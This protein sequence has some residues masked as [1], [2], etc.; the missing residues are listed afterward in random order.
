MADNNAVGTAGEF[1]AAGSYEFIILE[2]NPQGIARVTLNRPDSLNSLSGPLTKEL[3]TA[4]GKLEKDAAV[5]AII[6]TGAGRGFS[7]GADLK[8]GPTEG[9]PADWIREYYNPLIMKMRHLEKPIIAAV[10][11]VAAGA[12]F[13][14]A[15]ACDF[16]IVSEKARFISAFIRIGLV[17]DSGLAYFLP[18]LVGA[19]R[20]LE[21]TATGDEVSAAKA[22]EYGMVNRVVAPEQLEVETLAFANKLAQGPTYGI[23]LTKKLIN[24]G[25]ERSLSEVLEME[26]DAQHLAGKSYD[27][28]EGVTAFIEKRPARF[29]GR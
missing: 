3:T 2:Q 20:A 18:R 6:L 15:L 4:F 8:G 21:I 22:L 10:N 1:S 28:R 14:L 9:D 17:P 29:E 27:F 12:G 23:G 16:R 24:D 13:S 26:A 5:R 11:G 25:L 19:G 7:A